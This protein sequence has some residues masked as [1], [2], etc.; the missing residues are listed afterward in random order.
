[1]KLYIAKSS[2]F[3][4]MDGAEHL[5]AERKARLEKYNMP[6]DKQRCLAAGL[7]LHHVFA[8]RVEEIAYGEKG[9]PYFPDG[10]YFSISHSGDYVI[11]G[12]SELPIGVDIE[13]LGQYKEKLVRHCCT[14]EEILWLD[15]QDKSEFYR[16][17]TGKES[18]MKA[19][20]MGLAMS[21][22]SFSVLPAED[23]AHIVENR[24]WYLT[25]M[26]LP[27]YYLCCA[28]AG[29][30]RPELVYTD[31]ELLLGKKLTD[32]ERF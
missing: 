24:R 32:A 2:D 15:T 20:G 7:L 3:E 5:S 28:C 30:E 4:S 17:W 11:L 23:G 14:S 6:E 21:P 26:M 22:A 1:M 19:L 13:K 25:W 18:I 31:K 9:K 29:E 16:L 10:P 27:G 12:V 8:S